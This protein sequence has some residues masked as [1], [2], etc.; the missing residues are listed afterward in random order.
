MRGERRHP[1]KRLAIGCRAETVR[2]LAQQES[3]IHVPAIARE[4][5]GHPLDEMAEP[6]RNPTHGWRE[7]LN[8]KVRISSEELVGA[9]AAERD[10][11]FFKQKT[12]YEIGRQQRRIGKRFAEL[13]GNRIAGVEEIALA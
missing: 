6:C 2:Q 8:R 7:T 9:V 10:F 12:A 11:F 1:Q 3:P 4:P 13:A 5:G